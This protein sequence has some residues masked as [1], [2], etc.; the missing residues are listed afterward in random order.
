LTLKVYNVLGEEV[1]ALIAG[2]H[3][4]GTFRATW[5]ASGLPSGVYFYRLMAGEYVQ[6]KKAVLMK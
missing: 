3:A 5:D 2:D 4:A 6:T 1:A